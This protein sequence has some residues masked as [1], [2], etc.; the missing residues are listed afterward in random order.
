MP[1]VMNSAADQGLLQYN[2][3]RH[4]WGLE[5]LRFGIDARSLRWLG[6]LVEITFVIGSFTAS[7]SL[8]VFS[9]RLQKIRKE[10]KFADD[11]IWITDLCWWKRS[12]SQLSH[13]HCPWLL[14][15]QHNQLWPKRRKILAPDVRVLPDVA[16]ERI[17]R[18]QMQLQGRHD[19]LK[20][21]HDC[22]VSLQNA[23]NCWPVI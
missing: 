13:N 3:F 20:D 22:Q 1:F 5:S 17:P 11:W 10:I 6:N 8:F 7:L 9:T 19:G 4:N 16:E 12:L 2:Y 23:N 15:L 14:A 21:H 18:L